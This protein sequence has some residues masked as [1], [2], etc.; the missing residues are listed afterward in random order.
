MSLTYH[1]RSL[2]AEDIPAMHAGFL[3]GFSDYKVQF[4]LNREAFI[5]KFIVKLNIRFELSTGI[6]HN[7]ELIAFMFHSVNDYQG[8]RVLY[9][10]GTGVSPQHRGKRLAK[11]MYDYILPI[12]SNEGLS[13]SVLEVL[14]DNTK[15]IRAYESVGFQKGCV[16]KCFKASALTFSH[17][18]EDVT[19]IPQRTF[20]PGKYNYFDQAVP[21]FQDVNQQIIFDKDNEIIL[22]AFTGDQLAGYIIYHAETGR[23]SQIAVLKDYQNKGIG[24]RL[25]KEANWLLQDKTMTL[26]NLREEEKATV[27][28]LQKRGFVNEVDQYEMNLTF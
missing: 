16:F 21:S 9:N 20:N 17:V 7:K 3:N 5:K 6:F 1:I 26:I 4:K 13:H 23:I 28:F 15:A 19:I 8:N 25:L 18:N 14:M 24:S 22:E 12:A 10:G 11:E 27:A 2:N